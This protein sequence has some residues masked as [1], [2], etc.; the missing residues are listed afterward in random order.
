[1]SAPSTTAPAPVAV[2]PIRARDRDVSF[3]ELWQSHEPAVLAILR[4]MLGAA[5]AEDASQDVALQAYA[6]LHT[7]R[8]PDRFGGWICTIARNAARDVHTEHR[9]RQETS[10][11][12]DHADMLP[13][14]DEGDPRV[15]EEILEAVRK[16]PPAYREPLLLRLR[17]GLDGAEIASRLAMTQGSI[18]VNLCKGMKLL[19]HRLG[20]AFRD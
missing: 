13:A 17:D 16:L 1:M 12:D 2:E 4:R 14:R 19:R 3:D 5:A 15:A 6:N 9:R 18:R 11:D 8:D 10:L 20:T 7:L